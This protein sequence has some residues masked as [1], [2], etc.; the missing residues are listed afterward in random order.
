MV[1][2]NYYPDKKKSFYDK[3]I[4]SII[5]VTNLVKKKKNSLELKRAILGLSFCLSVTWSHSNPKICLFRNEGWWRSI[6]HLNHPWSNGFITRVQY[7]LILKCKL[8]FFQLVFSVF[9]IGN[10]KI[11]WS[12]NWFK[13]KNSSLGIVCLPYHIYPLEINMGRIKIWPKQC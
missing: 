3:R 11:F 13:K 1:L 12:K 6:I 2:L 8:D 5:N 9:T 4:L 10:K 7:R